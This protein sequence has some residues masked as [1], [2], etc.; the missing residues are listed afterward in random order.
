M[1]HHPCPTTKCRCWSSSCTKKSTTTSVRIRHSIAFATAAYA[2]PASTVLEATGRI[3][4]KC[5]HCQ[6]T[7]PSRRYGFWTSTA[8]ALSW[9]LR[10]CSRKWPSKR[11]A[12]KNSTSCPLRYASK[13]GSRCLTPCLRKWLRQSRSLRR[14]KTPA[15][16]AALMTCLK[17]FVPTYS[18][19]WTA[20]KSSWAAL[21]RMK[22]RARPTSA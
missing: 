22:G 2:A 9:T 4:P 20:M 5:L 13:T 15:S 6:S 21:G 14:L 18:K 12:L 11:P 19:P 1:S 16:R 7:T 3:R 17:S 10:A 8:S